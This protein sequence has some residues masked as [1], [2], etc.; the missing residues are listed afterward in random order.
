MSDVRHILD[1]IDAGDA[2]A[3]ADLLPL[4][5]AELR[6]LAAAHIARETPGQT[7]QATGLVHEAYLRLVGD[8]RPD[9]W[10][11]RGHFF[12]AAAEA[13]R[14]VLIDRCARQEEPTPGRARRRHDLSAS[15]RIDLPPND[16]IVDLDEALTK[17]GAVDPEAAE[18]VKLRVFAGM[19]ID[20]VADTRGISARTVKRDWAYARAWLGRELTSYDTRLS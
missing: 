6:K 9:R 20:E 11:G 19:T 18:V 7:L 14:R 4:V 12:A 2:R 10:S 5:Y 8:D 15:D 3:A 17:L 1:A 13:M 16:E